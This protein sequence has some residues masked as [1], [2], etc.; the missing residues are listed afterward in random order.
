MAAVSACGGNPKPQ[1][2][3]S[4][5]THATP[6]QAPA[7]SAA[8][9]APA[10]KDPIT[11]LIDASQQRFDDGERELKAGHLDRARASFDAALGTSATSSIVCGASTKAMSAP[12]SM[13]ALA[14][15]IASSIASTRMR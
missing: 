12:A 9:P 11:S 14:R 5:G 4:A 8:A 15:P 7:A 6:A 10:V 1:I 2:A 3:A 13:A